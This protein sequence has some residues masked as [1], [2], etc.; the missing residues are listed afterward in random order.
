MTRTASVS[1]DGPAI[2]VRPDGTTESVAWA[3]LRGVEIVT[4]ADGPWAED[5]F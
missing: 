3:D 4:T 2:I 1:C 5:V